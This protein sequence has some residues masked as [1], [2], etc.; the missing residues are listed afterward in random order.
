MTAKE[1]YNHALLVLGGRFPEGEAAIASDAHW[2]CCYAS[3][4]IQGR[5]PEGEAAIASNA[6]LAYWY[7]LVVIKRRWPEGEAAI[8]TDAKWAFY[9]AQYVL[10]G[11]FPQGEA[12]ICGS[13]WCS[14]YIEMHFDSPQHVVCGCTHDVGWGHFG[15]V[16]VSL[17][18]RLLA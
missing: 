14:L 10:G 8:A 11:R 13:E 12:A 6:R 3:D 7:A 16:S 18:D 4:V 9:Y 5:F 1:S 15:S 17:L 2:A